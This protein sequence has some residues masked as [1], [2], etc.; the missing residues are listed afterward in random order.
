MVWPAGLAAE[1][2]SKRL[3]SRT[4]DDR[5]YSALGKTREVLLFFSLGHFDAPAARR[6]QAGKQGC[7]K[8]ETRP[9]KRDED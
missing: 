4:E 5:R 9:S 3:N 2:P 6:E 8:L 7:S 1:E